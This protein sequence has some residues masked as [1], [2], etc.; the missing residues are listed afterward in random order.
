MESSDILA[1][2][3][4]QGY[5]MLMMVIFYGRRDLPLPICYPYII[6]EKEEK[7]SLE[8]KVNQVLE[9]LP[10]I[11]GYPKKWIKSQWT[12]ENQI[13]LI[14]LRFGLKDGEPKNLVEIGR[15]FNR[16]SK[17]RVRQVEKKLFQLLRHPNR[18]KLLKRFLISAPE[19]ANK[20]GV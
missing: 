20:Q 4:N 5:Q 12:R 2:K 17:E 6:D 3:I 11:F 1:E 7:I 15:E 9:T 10:I 8:E 14:I 19:E 16:I 13:K 18:S